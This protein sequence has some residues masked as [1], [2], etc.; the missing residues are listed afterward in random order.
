MCDFCDCVLGG[1]IGPL[2]GAVA[3]YESEEGIQIE[4][5]INSD[6]YLVIKTYDD[7]IALKIA[8]C[9]FCGDKL[10]DK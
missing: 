9:P 8:H 10:G 6:N 1:D 5:T 3:Q 4:A 2:H 7:T